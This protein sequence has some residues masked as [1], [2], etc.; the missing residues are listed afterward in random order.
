MFKTNHFLQQKKKKKEKVRFINNDCKTDS[1]N[2]HNVV[3]PCSEKKGKSHCA[4]S[5]K[6][7][8]SMTELLAF[9]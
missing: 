6:K 8:L 3:V 4:I 9:E 7:G 5:R 1:H 2:T